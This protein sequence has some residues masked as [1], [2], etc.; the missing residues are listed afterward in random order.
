MSYITGCDAGQITIVRLK[1]ITFHITCFE[2]MMAAVTGVAYL[3]S[4]K[5]GFASCIRKLQMSARWGK[6]RL[7]LIANG[8]N[9]EG[10]KHIFLQCLLWTAL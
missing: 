6:E 1:D 9:E 7:Q 4:D 8:H 10:R 2:L 3:I 5:S